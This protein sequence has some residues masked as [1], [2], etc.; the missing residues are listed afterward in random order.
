MYFT[1]NNAFFNWNWIEICFL[2]WVGKRYMHMQDKRQPAHVMLTYVEQ[3]NVYLA[4]IIDRWTKGIYMLQFKHNSLTLTKMEVM[5]KHT[6]A[7][8]VCLY[9]HALL[10]LLHGLER[11]V[12]LSCHSG[13]ASR[14]VS[15]MMCLTFLHRPHPQDAVQQANLGFAWI[16]F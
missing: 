13:L 9:I 16:H 10:L 14:N 4:V 6:C 15:Y 3:M 2:I 5:C 7:L 8:I 1:C 12:L 11:W